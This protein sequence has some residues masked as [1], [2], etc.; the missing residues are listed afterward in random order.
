MC[1]SLY[2][3]KYDPDSGLLMP[4][5]NCATCADVHRIR[6]LIGTRAEWIYTFSVRSVMGENNP[7]TKSNLPHCIQSAHVEGLQIPGKHRF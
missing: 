4:E 6:K 1:L 3:V 2:R 7:E 5:F